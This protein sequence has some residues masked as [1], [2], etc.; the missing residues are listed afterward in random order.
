MG[1]TIKR[2]TLLLLILTLLPLRFAFADSS[3]YW[4][5]FTDRGGI[6]SDALLAAKRVSDSEPK[7][8]S[9]RGRTL[10]KRR[11]FSESDLPVNTG[12]IA[13]VKIHAEGIRAISRYFNAVS[14]ELDDSML[15]M[16][17]ALP[18]VSELRPVY[19]R[20]VDMPPEMSLGKP[21]GRDAVE[22][23]SYG[24]SFG[25]LSMLGIHSMHNQGFRGDGLTIAVLDSGF[26]R[27]EHT[28]FDSLKVA[29][30]WD[31]VENDDD[32]RGDDHGTKVLSVMAALDNSRM[33]GAAPHAS[34]L[35]A[36]TEQHVGD[37]MRIEEDY[38]IAGIEWADSLGAD[39]VNI[40]LGYTDFGSEDTYTYE[41][42][43]G[44]T[45]LA[46]IACDAAAA[47][48]IM[49]VTSAGN[50]GNKEW[51]YVSVPADGDSVIAVGSLNLNR[52]ISSFSSIGPTFDGRVKPDF[53][54][55]GDNVLVADTNVVNSYKYGQ[56]TSYSAPLISGGV[57]LILEANPGWAYG[58][59]MAAMIA[60]AVQAGPETQY[61]YG[62]VDMFAA[63]GLT[64]VEP[65]VSAFR[66]FDPFPHPIAFDA[67]TPKI[68]FPVDVPEAGHL[69]TLKIY[70]FNGEIISK[71]AESVI[72]EGVLRDPGKAP[73]WDGTNF[74]GENVASGVYFYTIELFG[75]G[76][77]TG[78]IMVTR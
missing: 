52:T 46:T 24:D 76:R 28:A 78:K 40:S 33:I 74:S 66:A 8:R 26:D 3:P 23:Y 71:T 11:L 35:L 15:A 20:N 60:N 58:D 30:E 9:R 34:Y 37:D 69:L 13:E 14:V 50:E 19:V 21:A 18:F 70:D 67:V 44:D 22:A 53:V 32:I 16:V 31:F 72:E 38:L 36:R 48:G 62:L 25:Q 43:D 57:A 45:A 59:I 54:A 2:F 64:A 41:D 47:K 7:N 42:L 39:I 27:L 1:K 4:I 29:G 68:Y 75:Y 56:G 55:L 73:G 61:G 65:P 12:Y 77:H 17:S 5:F 63:A 10:S 6:D 49:V 51:R